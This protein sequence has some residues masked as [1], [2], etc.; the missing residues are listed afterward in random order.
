MNIGILGAGSVGGTLGRRWAANGHKVVFATRNPQSAKLRE[1]VSKAG[2]NASAGSN[3]EAAAKA[4]VLLV[5]TPWEAAEEA[6]RGA[7]DLSGKIVIDATNPLLPNLSGLAVGC[8]DSAAERIARSAP[9]AK[10]VKAFNTVGFNIMENPNFESGP[11]VMFYCGD[12][13]G[14]KQKVA[15]LISELGFNAVD[16]GPLTQA[17]VLEPFALLWVSLAY[18]AGQGRDI[19]FEFLRR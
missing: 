12:D 15:G 17:R 10:V 3:A 2:K 4:E 11:V 19:A 13:S 16:A 1:A 6:L 14:A 7:G 5:A 9:G 8:N 18:Q